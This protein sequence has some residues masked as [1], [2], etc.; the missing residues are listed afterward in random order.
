MI[1]KPRLIVTLRARY[2]LVAGSP[3]GLHIGIHLVTEATEG[4]G[5]CKS[6]KTSE[7]EKENDDAKSKEDLDCLEVSLSASL[8]LLE[9]IDPK[10]LDQMIKIF[11][12]SHTEIPAKTQFYNL[13]ELFQGK[14]FPAEMAISGKKRGGQERRGRPLRR[15]TMARRIIAFPIFVTL[16]ENREGFNG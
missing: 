13:L 14:L 16:S 4:G 12:S 15:E 3:P 10:D 7:D 8:R 11:Y 1:D 2:M 5:F 9:K 6:E